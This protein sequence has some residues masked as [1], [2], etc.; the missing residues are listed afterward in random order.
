MINLYK[1]F[2]KGYKTLLAVLVV[3]GMILTACSTLPTQTE[4]PTAPPEA[5]GT[6]TQPAEPTEAPIEPPPPADISP[7]PIEDIQNIEWQWVSLVETEP[8]SQSVVPH[9]ENYT[10]IL[11][12]DGTYHAKADC[13]LASGSYTTDGSQITFGMGPVTL[14][15][16]GPDSL[17]NQ[18]LTLLSNVASFGL[19]AENLI[20]ELVA[21]AGEMEF[22]NAGMAE[23]P[24]PT[25][26]PIVC[27]AGIDASTVTLDT[28]MLPYS[29][30]PNCVFGTPYDDNPPGPT[31]LPDHILVNFGVE[32]P[33]VAGPEDP[34]IYIIPVAEYIQL[35]AQAGNLSV[36]HFIAM[37]EGL[38][39]SQL[40]PVPTAGMPIL[41]FE[42]VSG[43]PDLQVQG[44]YLDITMG[45]G[46]RFITRF[47]QSPTPV[48]SDSPQMFYTFQGFSSDGDY[49]IAFFYPV[50]T[51]K[52]PSADRIS[53]EELERA[54]LNTQAY[55]AGKTTELNALVASD[56]EP[57]L[58]TLDAVIQS[59][60]WYIPPPP[61]EQPPQITGIN[62]QW[63]ELIESDPASQSVVPNP[64][65]YTLV[66]NPD[67]SLSI[68]ADCNVGSGTYT[69]S[70][71]SMTI[72]LG[73]LTRAICGPDSLSDQYLDLV[74]NVENFALVSGT[75][76]LSSGGGTS[77]MI[78]K[79]SGAVVLEP[80]ADETQEATEEPQSTPSVAPTS[81]PTNESP[82]ETPSG[83]LVAS[84]SAPS[85]GSVDEK[86][87]FD[88]SGSTPEDG[89]VNYAW[90]FGDGSP[91]G[92][93]E[94]V[95]HTY[96]NAGVYTV[97]LTITDANDNTATTIIDVTI[98]E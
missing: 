15:E 3:L 38:L 18:F 90:D 50:T 95:E 27:D 22:I 87:A 19:R 42:L 77:R 64:E 72:Q 69:V 57:N 78:F 26:T 88:G 23:M 24:E 44:R 66:F 5:V 97:I 70:G 31:G 32:S 17:Y 53:E 71:N 34:I 92:D 2:K 46:V 37:L 49:L 75:L 6:A 79:N 56:W 28:L 13:N 61:T 16:C 58:I 67:G 45:S 39:E 51:D 59:L 62:W 33:E 25:P 63:S 41:P 60:E 9:P 29:Y 54:E 14:A 98:A 65:S 20:L 10:L 12:P 86:I 80:T 1:P 43:V 89:I 11:R 82:D 83:A 73:A 84:I 4:A 21:G 96:S 74:E 93:G 85:Q 40:L 35:W 94:V 55:M 76:E 68:K 47:V 52:I 30:K 8:A 36:S 81:E 7:V 91:R 48:A